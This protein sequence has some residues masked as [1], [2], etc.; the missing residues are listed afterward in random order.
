MKAFSVG[1]RA[2]LLM[3]GIIATACAP[4]APRHPDQSGGAGGLRGRQ[5]PLTAAES[6]QKTYQELKRSGPSAEPWTKEAAKVFAKEATT[7]GDS[8]QATFSETEC[9]Q[10]GCLARAVYSS[11]SHYSSSSQSF[12]DGQG[13]QDWLGPKYRSPPDI[14]P[15]GTVIVNWIL[16]RPERQQLTR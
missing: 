12:T 14:R 16:F 9:Y 5:V 11:L 4:E 7:R 2:M 10:Q 6:Q 15:D 13:F 3:S 8:R 1:M